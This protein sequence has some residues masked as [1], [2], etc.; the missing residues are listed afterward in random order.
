[1]L[2]HWARV[3]ASSHA[4]K[5]W[6]ELGCAQFVCVCDCLSRAGGALTL[7][8]PLHACP[9]P[10]CL[11]FVGEM[12]VLGLQFQGTWFE[13]PVHRTHY[14]RAA[15]A[16]RRTEICFRA[17][18]FETYD[19]TSDGIRCCSSSMLAMQPRNRPTRTG[20]ISHAA[21]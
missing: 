17:D 19:A 20:N 1:M 21:H 8:K 16:V 15:L 3:V 13:C 9:F 12:R 11:V 10:F 5:L 14:W 4:W 2:S 6:W 7:L 18:G